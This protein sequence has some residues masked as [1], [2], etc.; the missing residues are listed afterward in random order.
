MSSKGV[1]MRRHKYQKGEVS[2]FIVVFSMLLITVVV[3]GFTRI[4]V[5][6][7]QQATASD[8]SQSAYDSAQAGVEDAKR[9]IINLHAICDSG[10]AA[11]CAST[12]AKINSSVCN[13]SVKTLSDINAIATSKEVKVQTNGDNSLDQAYTCVKIALNTADYVGKLSANS[14]QII[15]LKGVGAFNT[16]QI[17]WFNASDLGSTNNFNINLQPGASFSW[18][19]LTQNKWVFNR[20]AIMRTQLIQFSSNNGFRVSDFD[21]ASGANSNANTLFLYPSGNSGSSS[22]TIDTLAFINRDVRRTP[23][24]APTPVSCSGNIST[25]SYACTVKLQLPIQINGGNREAYLRLTSLYNNSSFRVTLLNTGSGSTAVNFDGVQP[26]ID[27]TGRANS[28]FR[29][30]STRVEMIDPNF[31]YPD[32]E[33]NISGNLCK[34]FRVTDRSS[35][36]ST[37]CT[38]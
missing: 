6:D 5:Q 35:D 16:I 28:L 30:V 38:P 36:Y 10:N 15:P 31:P 37:N 18:P 12:L 23:K 19:L 20:P 4:M 27:S 32:A 25:M 29:R 17:Q 13:D 7:Q 1:S 11:A 2:I 8:L 26:N 24:G 33:M 21:S 9:A 14:S 22:S 3:V 34:D